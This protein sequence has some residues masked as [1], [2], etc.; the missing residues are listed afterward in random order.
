MLWGDDGDDEASDDIE[1]DVDDDVDDDK[2]EDDHDHD[3]N[4][5]VDD[6]DVDDVA[7]CEGRA[8]RD[9]GANERRGGSEGRGGRGV[10]VR[11]DGDVFGFPTKSSWWWWCWSDDDDGGRGFR[12]IFYALAITTRLG[13]YSLLE[14]RWLEKIH[15]LFSVDS[16]SWQIL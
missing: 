12:S 15:Y 8:V 11:D 13:S 16:I 7:G 4:K 14:I 1:D 3:D 5:D 2:D 6:K 9:L 10:Q